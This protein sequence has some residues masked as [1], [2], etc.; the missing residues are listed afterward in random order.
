MLLPVVCVDCTSPD[1]GRLYD[2]ES[3]L[4]DSVATAEEL[5]LAEAD[6]KLPLLSLLINR[7]LATGGG[8][9]AGPEVV[10]IDDAVAELLLKFV[11]GSVLADLGRATGYL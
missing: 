10:K 7:L 5:C 6:K 2:G 8:W 4:G 1:L 11:C 3:L 9:G